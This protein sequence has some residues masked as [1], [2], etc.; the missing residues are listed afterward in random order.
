[1]IRTKWRQLVVCYSRMWR[2]VPHLHGKTAR[3]Q[4]EKNSRQRP[5]GWCLLM[6]ED[7]F[8]HVVFQLWQVTEQE[9]MDP[10]KYGSQVSWIAFWPY[11]CVTIRRRYI[12][13]QALALLS[14]T[15]L[16][17]IYDRRLMQNKSSV[18]Y[19]WFLLFVTI[20]EQQYDVC[21]SNFVA[22]R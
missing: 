7:V 5:C 15:W 4:K 18:L 9:E 20:V 8:V 2:H 14:V 19:L 16:P 12:F 11:H 6:F 17:K 21:T 3:K 10:W 13:K 1:M 22:V